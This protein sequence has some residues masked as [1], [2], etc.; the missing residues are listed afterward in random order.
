M[1][2]AVDT[3]PARRLL[4]RPHRLRGQRTWAAHHRGRCARRGPAADGY[5]GPSGAPGRDGRPGGRR[6]AVRGGGAALRLLRHDGSA[7]LQRRRLGRRLPGFFDT[8]TNARRHESAWLPPVSGGGGRIFRRSAP[9]RRRRVVVAAGAAAPPAAP[10]SA[11]RPAPGL[12]NRRSHG[13][14][15]ARDR[16]RRRRLDHWLGIRFGHDRLVAS[17]A[18]GDRR[19]RRPDR[20]DQSRRRQRRGRRLWRLGR[21]G[22]LL[23]AR[24]P[25]SSRP[26]PAASEKMSPLGSSMPRC[27]ASRSTNWRATI[28]SSVLDALFSSMP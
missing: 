20:L 23:R 18:G 27:R 26:W 2:G 9:H 3:R 8:Q 15:A 19:R 11:P 21:G 1:P 4:R 16:R 6:R 7:R 14:S 28:S 10:P 5:A 22:A 24:R 12:R 17:G 13:S 25:P